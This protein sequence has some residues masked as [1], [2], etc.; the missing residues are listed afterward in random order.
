[1]GADDL[2]AE[3]AGLG[4]EGRR[5][6]ELVFDLDARRAHALEAG[7]H[8]DDERFVGGPRLGLGLEDVR[9]RQRVDVVGELQALEDDLDRRRSDALAAGRDQDGKLGLGLL[10]LAEE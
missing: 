10:A 8:G 5:A 6:G 1:M 4:D 7:P 3:L 9:R 2:D